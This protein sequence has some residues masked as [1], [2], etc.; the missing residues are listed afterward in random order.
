MVADGVVGGA[1]CSYR[2]LK[3]AVTEK[4]TQLWHH[5]DKHR[6]MPTDLKAD[7]TPMTNSG[8]PIVNSKYWEAANLRTPQ[9]WS[10]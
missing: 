2:D 9:R 7:P 5:N 6:N 4:M 8:D 3:V 10:T 1:D